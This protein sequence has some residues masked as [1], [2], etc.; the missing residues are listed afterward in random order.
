[1]RIEPR[2][3]FVMVLFCC[4][5]LCCRLFQPGGARSKQLCLLDKPSQGGASPRLEESAQMM[6]AET[7]CFNVENFGEAGS[8]SQSL[9]EKERNIRIKFY[10]SQL[11]HNF[12]FLNSNCPTV[13]FTPL[14]FLSMTELQTGFPNAKALGCCRTRRTTSPS[15]NSLSK[16]QRMIKQ[17]R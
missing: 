3:W 11:L 15:P 6:L 7:V 8:L 4:F 10:Q 14:C 13:V 1:M 16:I 9:K 2:P 12:F 17:E 5:C